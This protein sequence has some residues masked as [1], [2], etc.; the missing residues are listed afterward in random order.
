MK[1]YVNSK[2]LSFLNYKKNQY[3]LISNKLKLSFKKKILGK[4]IIPKIHVYKK[5][6]IKIKNSYFNS[7]IND[8]NMS[9]VYSLAKQLKISNNSFFRSLKSF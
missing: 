4:L 2:N 6:K 1:N 7:N 9:F 3:S 8:E 5:F